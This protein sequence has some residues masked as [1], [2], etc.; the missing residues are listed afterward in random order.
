[1]AFSGMGHWGSYIQTAYA[2]QLSSYTRRED[3]TDE[4]PLHFI[5]TRDLTLLFLL[6]DYTILFLLFALH[7]LHTDGIGVGIPWPGWIACRRLLRGILSYNMT[8]GLEDCRYGE[9]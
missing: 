4:H 7:A 3:V 5:G 6:Y 2:H 8:T 1:M 9:W